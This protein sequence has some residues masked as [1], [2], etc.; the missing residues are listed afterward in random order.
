MYRRL[1]QQRREE[2][3]PR[4]FRRIV[5]HPTI[6]IEPPGIVPSIED[7]VLPRDATLVPRRVEFFYEPRRK[8]VGFDPAIHIAHD[9]GERLQVDG[10]PIP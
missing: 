2:Q 5:D 6:A 7:P 10:A 9:V 1:A 3:F 8:R 4:I